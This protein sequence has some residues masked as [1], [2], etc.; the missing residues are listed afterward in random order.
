M[1]V[2]EYSIVRG[3]WEQVMTYIKIVKIAFWFWP[4]LVVLVEIR[5]NG[6]SRMTKIQLY[7]I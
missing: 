3:I 2:L 7:N 1:L 6:L 4:I 5:M